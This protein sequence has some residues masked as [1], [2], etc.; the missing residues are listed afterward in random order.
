MKAMRPSRTAMAAAMGMAA[1][2]ARP[3]AATPRAIMAGEARDLVACRSPW[4]KV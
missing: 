4:L 3:M 1:A 2:I